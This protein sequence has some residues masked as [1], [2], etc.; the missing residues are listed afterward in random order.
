MRGTQFLISTPISGHRLFSIFV[1]QPQ[2]ASL[3]Q[4]LCL[5]K[6]S[7]ACQWPEASFLAVISLPIWYLLSLWPG[8]YESFWSCDDRKWFLLVWNSTEAPAMLMELFI[9]R[10]P[11]SVHHV[12]N[13][14]PSLFDSSHTYVLLQPLTAVTISTQL[15]PDSILPQLDWLIIS[16][17]L[18]LVQRYLWMGIFSFHFPLSTLSFLFLGIKI[19]LHASPWLRLCFVEEPKL[20][21]CPT[22]GHKVKQLQLAAN[23]SLLMNRWCMIHRE[24][25]LKAKSW[26]WLVIRATGVLE[27]KSPRVYWETQW[28]KETNSFH[29]ILRKER[30]NDISKNDFNGPI[31]KKLNSRIYNRGPHYLFIHNIL[32][33]M[34]ALAK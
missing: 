11:L 16:C 32:F 22:Y 21:Y 5:P 31:P 33:S 17:F 9:L 20:R 26:P 6:L 7:S 29:S 24:A 2:R 14:D 28:Q 27:A 18:G 3:A 12:C 1:C 13:L 25:I 19:S 30:W 4:Q 15:W 34:A 10:N 23:I 8:K